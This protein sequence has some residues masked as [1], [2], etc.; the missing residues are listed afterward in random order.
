MNLIESSSVNFLTGGGTNTGQFMGFAENSAIIK[1]F[2]LTGGYI[3]IMDLQANGQVQGAPD[4]G[5]TATLL[6]SVLLGLGLL[7]RKFRG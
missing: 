3:S 4:G 5:T 2:A 1:H 7:R 6:G